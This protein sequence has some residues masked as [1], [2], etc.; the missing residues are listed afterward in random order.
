M[1]VRRPGTFAR[2][3]LC[4]QAFAWVG[5][6]SKPEHYP[7]DMQFTWNAFILGMLSFAIEFRLAH[8]L[9]R[10]IQDAAEDTAALSAKLARFRSAFKNFQPDVVDWICKHAV[11][12]AVLEHPMYALQ[13]RVPWVRG[14][15]GLVGD[16]AH[17]MPPNLSQGTPQAL[18]DAVQLA[19]SIKEHGATAAALAHYEAVRPCECL[20]V[21]NT[22]E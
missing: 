14:C 7:G 9:R 8:V 10:Y 2:S 19:A 15:V 21:C 20:F 16:A 3:L 22:S 1:P 17:V 6:V 5:A 11:P 13:P 12:E 18:E 4:Q